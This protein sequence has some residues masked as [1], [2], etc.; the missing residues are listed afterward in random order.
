MSARHEQAP[1]EMPRIRELTSPGLQVANALFRVAVGFTIA[2]LVTFGAL[3]VLGIIVES[4]GSVRARD[5]DALVRASMMP[6]L[7]SWAVMPVLWPLVI[8]SQRFALYSAGQEFAQ[9][10]PDDAPPRGMR[11]VYPLPPARALRANSFVV[12]IVFGILLLV[13]V[14][15]TLFM[16]GESLSSFVIMLIATAV[17]AGMCAAGRWM[18]VLARRLEP[19][20][21][22]QISMVMLKWT[23]AAQSADSAERRLRGARGADAA[24]GR[25][26]AEASALAAV[27]LACAHRAV[28][29]G[30]RSGADR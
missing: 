30:I 22:V 3:V 25:A 24:P 13:C 7:I 15:M 9:Q 5:L 26:A 16:R 4:S 27:R 21:Q 11:E 19:E 18:F 17:V 28:G 12:M 1:A 14:P 29:Q 6:V 2:S 20:Q 8:V 10:H 23:L